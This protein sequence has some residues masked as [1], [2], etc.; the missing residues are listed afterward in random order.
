[1]F[2]G[3]IFL[4]E[5][6][7][8]LLP[9]T[10]LPGTYHWF[11]ENSPFGAKKRDGATDGRLIFHFP[12]DAKPTPENLCGD[13]HIF[14]TEW[15]ATFQGVKT[16]DSFDENCW[17]VKHLV[18]ETDYMEE[19]AEGSDEPTIVIYKTADDNGNRIISFILD[20]GWLDAEVTTFAKKQS[21]PGVIARLTESEKE[22]LGMGLES[23]EVEERALKADKIKQEEVKVKVAK[24]ETEVV[25]KE[26]Q[27]IKKEEEENEKKPDVAK[28]KGMG[29][30]KAESDV[31]QVVA[32]KLSKTSG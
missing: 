31:D 4:Q 12:P 23:E 22:R 10:T 32:H 9:V 26:P 16:G 7:S 21:T 18:W 29:K 28:N 24:E 25:K 8:D 17:I 27:A 15:R 13:I 2:A 1:L 30:R 19:E 11:W 3:E 20:H 6:D 14:D 5:R